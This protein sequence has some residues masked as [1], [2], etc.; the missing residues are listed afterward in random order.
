MTNEAADTILERNV[1]RMIRRWADPVPPERI[2]GACREFLR[3]LEV[4]PPPKSSAWGRLGFAAALLL[5]AI[6][7][8][9]V[10]SWRGDRVDPPATGVPAPTQNEPPVKETFVRADLLWLARHQNPDGSW[11]AVSFQKQCVA[12]D[13]CSGTGEA[14]YDTGLTALSLMAFLGS[15]YSQL[16]KDEYPDPVVPGRM[17]HFGQVVKSG[18]KWLLAHQDR[19]GCLGDRGMKY[20][21][22]HAI[23][24][25]CLSEAYG[26]TAS[27]PLREPAQRA[28][29]FLVLAQNPGKGWRYSSRSG[30][31]DTS[32]SGWVVFALKSAELSGLQFPKACYA[33][34]LAW[35]N[36]VSAPDGL[37][38]AGYNARGT[39][40]V[41]VPGRNEQFE[42]HPTMSAIAVLSRIFLGQKKSEPA[43][44]SVGLLVADLPA[45]KPNKI[46]FYYWHFASLALYQYDG[47]DGPMWKAWSEP[48]KDALVPN[49]RTKQD[50]CRKGSWDPDRERWGFEGGRVYTTAMGALTL[51]TYYRYS[52]VWE[53]KK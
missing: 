25:L 13:S 49:Q 52:R 3:R 31:N 37:R 43:L 12:G 29:D 46:D 16:S 40:R 8:W 36:E 45:W 18:L 34:A 51:E 39:G 27:Q 20:M 9:A 42:S 24:A 48:M 5:G 53:K 26:M 1:G 38:E 17:L 10:F 30:D 47:P 33:D 11:G 21:Y 28:I 23:A 32:V 2:E 19:E 7:F 44:A 15:G 14:D 41:Y 50:G 6:G 22:N 35:L 4:P